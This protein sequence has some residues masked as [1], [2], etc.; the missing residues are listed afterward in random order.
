MFRSVDDIGERLAI[1]EPQRFAGHVISSRLY[2]SPKA[3]WKLNWFLRDFGYDAELLERDE[4]DEKQLV[5]LRGVIKI[6]P[7]LST[8]VPCSDSTA[9]RQPASGKNFTHYSRTPAGG[10][11]TYSFTQI[12]QS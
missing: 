1:P 11:M 3:L 7:S 8:A 10:R 4:V 9:L 12:R 5:G 2:C 6:S